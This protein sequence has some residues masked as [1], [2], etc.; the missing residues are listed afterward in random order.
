MK[1]GIIQ[2]VALA[3]STDVIHVWFPGWVVIALP[4]LS[5]N[6]TALAAPDPEI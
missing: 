3:H 4:A 5:D 1:G 2:I 6:P